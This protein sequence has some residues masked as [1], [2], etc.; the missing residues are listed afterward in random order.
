[1]FRMAYDMMVHMA[2]DMM[3]R[4]AYDMMFRMAYDMTYYKVYDTILYVPLYILNSYKNKIKYLYYV[5]FTHSY[6]SITY[7]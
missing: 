4:M 1:M 6:I 5:I 7:M 3:F 2:Y